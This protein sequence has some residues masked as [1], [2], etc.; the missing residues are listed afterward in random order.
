MSSTT[1]EARS[2]DG[3]RLLTRAWATSGEPRAAILIVHGLGE[4]SGRYERVGEWFAR[5][6]HAVAAWDHRGFGA[7]EG[8]RG[9]VDRW[10][11]YHDD[12]QDRLTA[13]RSEHP[14]LPVVLYGHSMGGLSALGY[15]LD[16]SRPQPDL[17]VLSAP[18]VADSLAAWKHLAAPILGR[19]VPHLRIPND[20]APEQVSRD[21]AVHARDRADPLIVPASTARFGAEGIA[22]QA[23]V[24]AAMH[25]LA[26]ETL[27]IASLADPLVPPASSEPLAASP[28]V[29]RRTYPGLR[30]EIHNEPE[31]EAVYA[32]V[33]DWLEERL[34]ARP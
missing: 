14:G 6:G 16:A 15:A 1:G 24:R 34:A 2:R 11:R 10:S 5:A 8:E 29:T 13:L 4:H 30:H 31:G 32:E 22:E 3:L 7:S 19:F 26:V 23:R 12:T 25:G 20:I 27:V 28:L 21:P 33:I 17:L 18:G 9:W